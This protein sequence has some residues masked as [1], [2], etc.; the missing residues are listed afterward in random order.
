MISVKLPNKSDA[1]ELLY[2]SSPIF[3]DP[4]ADYPG[5]PDY[6]IVGSH[7]PKIHAPPSLDL[8][9]LS[10]PRTLLLTD[11]ERMLSDGETVDRLEGLI[12]GFGVEVIFDKQEYD[13]ILN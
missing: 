2:F 10:L 3:E 1:N 6:V 13:F 9:E 7:G 5:K 4:Y 8:I 12:D 11:G